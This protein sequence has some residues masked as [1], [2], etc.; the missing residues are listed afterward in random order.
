MLWESTSYKLQLINILRKRMSAPA[1]KYSVSEM[2]IGAAYMQ[3]ILK[4][5]SCDEQGQAGNIFI[6]PQGWN[7]K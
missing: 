6:S 7:E 3:V 2:R 4:N 1:T 5:G